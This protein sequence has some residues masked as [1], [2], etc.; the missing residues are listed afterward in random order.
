MLGQTVQSF[1][2]SRDAGRDGAFAGTWQR[3]ESETLTGE[4]VIQCKF[5]GKI[6]HSLLLS[7]LD[8]EFDKV[9]RPAQKGLC[10][11][12]ILLTNAGVSGV[13]EEEVRQLFREAGAKEVLVLGESWISS[14]IRENKRLRMLVPRVYGLGDLSQI[15]DERAYAQ[16]RVVLELMREDLAKVVVTDAYNRAAASLDKH[17]FVLLVGEAAAGKTTIASLLAIAAVDQ[18]NASMLKLD[19]PAKVVEHWNP[20]EPSQFFWIDDAFGV[21][22]YEEF[23]VHGWNHALPQVKTM[24]RSGAKIVMTSRDY[25]YNRARKDLKEGA[26]PLI[27]ESQVVIDVQQLTPGEKCQILYNHL[28]LGQ[29]P[30][31]FRTDIKPYL[32]QVSLHPRFIPETARR[33][34]DPLFTPRIVYRQILPGPVRRE[35]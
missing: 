30:R 24:L 8:D 17:S 5:T 32:E 20:E 13:R 22:Q 23:L 1:L 31:P 29:Q 34:S 33:L 9:K 6:G 11:I 35:A 7:E 26:F 18:W 10:D 4:F 12:Y 28:K 25:I 27:R 21:T 19:D 2:D 16:G 15:L 3:Q 14:Q